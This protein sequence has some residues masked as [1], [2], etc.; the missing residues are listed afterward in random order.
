MEFVQGPCPRAESFRAQ[1]FA[2]GVLSIVNLSLLLLGSQDGGSACEL[3]SMSSCLEVSVRSG[4]CWVVA[5]F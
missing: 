4:S 3:A 2:H 5:G 1:Q